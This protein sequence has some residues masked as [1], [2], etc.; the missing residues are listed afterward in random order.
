MAKITKH[1]G[2]SD[3]NFPDQDPRVLGDQPTVNPIDVESEQDQPED[4]PDQPDEDV[5]EQPES[6]GVPLAPSGGGNQF[7]MVVTG[8]AEVQPGEP[9]PAGTIQ[10]TK[11]W[12][13]EDYV[14]AE[15]ALG[16][17]KARPKDAGGPR[18]SL[19]AW[20]EKIAATKPSGE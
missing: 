13:G 14:R 5:T 6:G 17:E 18:G 9:V 4:E 15:R 1:G 3:V 16:A 8:S 19:M 10:E 11:D 12:V 7:E 20:L 2:P